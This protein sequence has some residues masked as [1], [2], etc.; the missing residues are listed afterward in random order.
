MENLFPIHVPLSGEANEAIPLTPAEF[1][2]HRSVLY[3][4]NWVAKGSRP[5]A[6]GT[7]SILAAR[8]HVATI[9]DALIM[10]NAITDI[11]T[12]AKG[13]LTIWR[14]SLLNM[15]FLSASDA[16][17]VGANP[18]TCTELTDGLIDDY[19]Q[20]AWVVLTTDGPPR[21]SERFKISP[22]HGDPL[23]AREGLPPRW[24]ERQ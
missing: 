18:D 4:L 17:D 9:G 23:E 16:A 12:R 2:E 22:A 24:R 1:K 8:P 15:C 21:G 19:V 13:T 20:G 6:V 11:R 5:E 7:A 10:N 3:K 14:H